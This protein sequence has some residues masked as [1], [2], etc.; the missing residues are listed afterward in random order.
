MLRNA[1]T[2]NVRFPWIG[3]EVRWSPQENGDARGY[4]PA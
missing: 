4:G 1:P 2:F 3:T